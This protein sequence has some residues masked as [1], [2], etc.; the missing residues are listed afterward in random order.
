MMTLK[1][2]GP[3]LSSKQN[4]LKTYEIVYC[5]SEDV[6]II[7]A[8]PVSVRVEGHEPELKYSLSSLLISFHVSS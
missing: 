4:N 3:M 1:L 2:S 6:F 8:P 7:S 5:D